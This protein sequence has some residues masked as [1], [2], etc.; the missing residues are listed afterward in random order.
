[1]AISISFTF[2]MNLLRGLLLHCDYLASAGHPELFS[3]NQIEDCAIRQLFEK[4]L[5]V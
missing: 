3:R 1:M 5:T 2:R 4:V